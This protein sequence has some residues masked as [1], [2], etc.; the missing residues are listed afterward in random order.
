MKLQYKIMR[1]VSLMMGAALLLAVGYRILWVGIVPSVNQLL[2]ILFTVGLLAFC[3]FKLPV[4]AQQAE[5]AF[6]RLSEL[7]CEDEGED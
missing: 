6:D 2:F 4:M 3:A 5:D 1:W 7:W